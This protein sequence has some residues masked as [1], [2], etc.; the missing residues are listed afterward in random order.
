MERGREK[1]LERVRAGESK[2]RRRRGKRN[3]GKR[4]REGGGGGWEGGHKEEK[5]GKKCTP[6]GGHREEMDG[7]AYWAAWYV[8]AAAGS[9]TGLRSGAPA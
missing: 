7:R 2:I 9:T 1:V 4:G 6:M 5:K 3:E 8:S